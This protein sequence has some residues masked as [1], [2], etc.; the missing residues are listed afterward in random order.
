MNL[1]KLNMK[2]LSDA[3][4]INKA[5]LPTQSETEIMGK[6]W[7]KRETRKDAG[8]ME[9]LPTTDSRRTRH[10]CGKKRYEMLQPR[11]HIAH[12]QAEWCK[13]QIST[14]R[15]SDVDT[16]DGQSKAEQ[17]GTNRSLKIKEK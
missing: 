7:K 10:V 1:K 17:N 6:N 9:A 11:E 13:K 3:R 14:K 5:S 4:M 2:F 8:V 12:R 15:V 16:L